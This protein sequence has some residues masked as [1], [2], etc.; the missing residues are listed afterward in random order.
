MCDI[1]MILQ[2][3]KKLKKWNEL[4]ENKELNLRETFTK[5]ASW[6]GHAKSADTYYLRQKV[7]K[8]CNLLY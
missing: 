7:R 1:W 4:Y 3:Y 5:L 6:E 8:K 2:M